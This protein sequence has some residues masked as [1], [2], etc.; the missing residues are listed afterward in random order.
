[1][2]AAIEDRVV[3]VAPAMLETVRDQPAHDAVRFGLVVGGGNDADWI[4][5]TVLT[6]ELLLEE[7]GIARDQRVADR[8]IR[9]VER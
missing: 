7:L 4:A 2:I 6:P 1:V 3:G 8:R 9:T 5:V